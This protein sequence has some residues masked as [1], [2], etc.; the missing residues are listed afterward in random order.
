MG[1]LKQNRPHQARSFISPNC[2][3][4]WCRGRMHAHLSV[5]KSFGF[6]LKK[7]EWLMADCGI[8]PPAA[9]LRPAAVHEGRRRR[10]AVLQLERRPGGFPPSG[11]RRGEVAPAAAAG[12]K[13]A[14]GLRGSC[15][16]ESELSFTICDGTV[17]ACPLLCSYPKYQGFF[18]LFLFFKNLMQIFFTS[19]GLHAKPP[20]FLQ[21]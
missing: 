14:E 21:P 6:F 11:H 3:P 10:A 1:P 2:A 18:F 5:V 9:E 19:L 15:D 4:Y 13:H 8:L 17:S 20:D 12:T 7:A 16:Q